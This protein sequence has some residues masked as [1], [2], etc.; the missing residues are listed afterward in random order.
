MSVS[1]FRQMAVC[2]LTR[3]LPFCPLSAITRQADTV[4]E[5]KWTHRVCYTTRHI[6]SS[7]RT[8]HHM[9]LRF[10]INTHVCP[11]SFH[12]G[13]TVQLLPRPAQLLSHSHIPES[14][15]PC[16]AHRVSNQ[17]L[18]KRQTTQRRAR[19]TQAGV[20]HIGRGRGDHERVQRAVYPVRGG[21]SAGGVHT[22]FEGRCS[23]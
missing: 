10:R 11:E 7:P 5:V 19:R 20:T 6:V 18:L 17:Q 23:V 15:P 8:M 13:Q 4:S 14:H 21:S 9:R 2:G 1:E 3:R 12:L 22:G 16:P